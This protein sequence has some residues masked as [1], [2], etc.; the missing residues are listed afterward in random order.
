MVKMKVYYFVTVSSGKTESEVFDEY[1]DELVYNTKDKK[2]K[3]IKDTIEV[4]SEDIEYG[5]G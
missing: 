4:V 5:E 3:L 1:P 2:I